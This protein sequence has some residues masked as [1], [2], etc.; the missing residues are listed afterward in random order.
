MIVLA[1]PSKPFKVTPK[2]TLQRSEV[3]K[4]Y[5][6]E[7]AEAYRTFDSSPS[8]VDSISPPSSWK[9]GDCVRFISDAVTRILGHAL[10]GNDDFFQNG[11][12]RYEHL[13]YS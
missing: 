7:I 8:S 10:E 13:L 2:Q 11:L 1:K 6:D 5:A 12:N 3:L 9:E 4:D